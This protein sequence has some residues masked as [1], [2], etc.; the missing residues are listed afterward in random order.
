MASDQESSGFLREV[1]ADPDQD[2]LVV[3]GAVDDAAKAIVRLGLPL[4]GE[5]P[6]RRPSL[7]KVMADTE[8]RFSKTLAYLGGYAIEEP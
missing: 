2:P 5:P 1:L 3:A 6:A 4:D 7:E 8:K